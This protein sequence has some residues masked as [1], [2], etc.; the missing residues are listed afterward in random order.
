MA[1]LTIKPAALIFSFI[2]SA[3][4]LQAQEITHPLDPL[5]WQ[6]Y[7]TVLEVLRDAEHLDR[8]TRFSLVS[9]RE[10]PKALVW[11]WSQGDAFPRSAFAV[12]RQGKK[13]YEAVVDVAGRRVVSWTPMQ[14]DEPNW[15]GEE[16]TALDDQVKE[17]PDFLAA[18][19]RRGITDLTFIDCTA[20]PPGYFGTP[21]EQGRRIGHVTCEDVR[22]VRN[23]WARGIA[24]L[25][26]LVDMIEKKVIRVIDEGSGA[27]PDVS[28]DYDPA[29]IGDP[30]DVPGPIRIEQPHGRGFTLRG[31]VVE[32]QKWRFHLRSDQRMGTVISTV[33]YRDGDAE[34][35]ILYQGYLSEIFVPYMDPSSDWYAR[36]FLDAGEFIAGGLTKPLLPGVDCPD[37]A[38]YLDAVLSTD[39]GWPQDARRMIC[40]YERET[41][42]PSWRHFESGVEGRNKRD[43]VVRSAA[44]RMATI[45]S[46]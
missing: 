44:A 12:V 32:W 11:E 4:P 8:V 23:T 28:A 37:N 18:M 45:P 1:Q 38:I 3:A 42:D 36:N 26:I 33:T 10:P 6:E 30:R 25:I 21:E 27:M 46:M 43:L 13:S 24:G 17:H 40:L 15:I 7:W 5:S 14:G 2:L 19:E 34:R 20:L 39:Q 9:L 35:R 22:N 31:H 16:F 29:S 41:G